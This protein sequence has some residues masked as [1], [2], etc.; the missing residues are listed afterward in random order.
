MIIKKFVCNPFEQNTFVV[1]DDSKEAVIIDAGCYKQ[2]EIDSIDNY[3][4]DNG[5]TIKYILLTHSHFDHC[6]SID[7]F[8]KKYQVPIVASEKYNI[9]FDIYEVTARM[10]GLSLKKPQNP[11]I[12]IKDNDEI[13]F[14][15]TVFRCLNIEGHTPCGIVYVNDEKKIM[16]SGDILFFQSIG[17]SDLPH[18]DHKK[19]IEGIKNKLISLTSNYKVYCGHGTETD[20]FYERD[21]NMFL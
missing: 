20:I 7:N 16:F 10:F 17:R 21:N 2:S 18:G 1:S 4:K 3:I 19:L 14:G 12:L 8:R 5:L 6:I 9:V 11:T 15:I 13:T